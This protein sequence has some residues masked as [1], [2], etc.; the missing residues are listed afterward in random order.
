MLISFV[1]IICFSNNEIERG[2]YSGKSYLENAKP[3]VGFSG[4]R[5]RSLTVQSIGVSLGVKF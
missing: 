5:P 2:L 4:E 1:H 3:L